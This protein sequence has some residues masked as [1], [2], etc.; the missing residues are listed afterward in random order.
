VEVSDAMQAGHASLP[1]GFGLQSP[2]PDGEMIV[3]GVAP[4]SLTASDWRD[5]FAGTPWH[6]HVPARIEPAST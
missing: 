6:K 5:E 3:T 4:N 1:N 2:G